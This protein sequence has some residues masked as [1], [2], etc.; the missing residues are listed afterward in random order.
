MRFAFF[1]PHVTPHI[2]LTYLSLFPSLKI[3]HDVKMEEGEVM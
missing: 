1:I 3:S 2:S